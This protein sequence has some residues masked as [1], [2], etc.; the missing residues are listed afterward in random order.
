MLKAPNI[1]HV[2]GKVITIEMPKPLAVADAPSL[3]LIDELA[4][5]SQYQLVAPVSALRRAWRDRA[6]EV[7]TELRARNMPKG[8]I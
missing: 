5:A 6:N 7:Y 4:V 2:E 1:A 3:A 8:A